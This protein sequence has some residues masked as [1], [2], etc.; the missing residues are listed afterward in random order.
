M[1]CSSEMHPAQFGACSSQL[2][3]MKALN[4]YTRKAYDWLLQYKCLKLAT[5]AGKVKGIHSTSSA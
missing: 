3:M 4:K 5:F 1:C 2:R